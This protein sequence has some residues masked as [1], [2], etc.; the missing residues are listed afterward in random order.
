MVTVPMPLP[1]RKIAEFPEFVTF[2]QSMRLPRISMF[3]PA[4]ICTQS[5]WVSPCTTA[6]SRIQESTMLL[7]LVPIFTPSP[8]PE[9]SARRM[10]VSQL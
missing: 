4:A 7:L 5:L 10:S 1:C 8:R 3:V 9:M 6:R 2:G